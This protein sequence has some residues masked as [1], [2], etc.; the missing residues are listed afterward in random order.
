MLRGKKKK[1]HTLRGGTRQQTAS[2]Y[3]ASTRFP[4]NPDR[5]QAFRSAPFIMA[6]CTCHVTNS[7][8]STERVGGGASEGTFAC[9]LEQTETEGIWKL[10]DLFFC[11]FLFFKHSKHQRSSS[12]TAGLWLNFC[13]FKSFLSAGKKQ[14]KQLLFSPFSQ[15]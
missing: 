12:S 7:T 3:R 15:R 4:P 8:F 6:L 1:Q 5:Q 13:S 11:F 10:L 9:L 2:F 14:Q